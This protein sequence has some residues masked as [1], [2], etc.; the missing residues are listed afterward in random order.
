VATDWNP[1][2]GGIVNDISIAGTNVYVAG[3][4]TTIGGQTRNRIAALS[5]VTGL[6]TAWN[7]SATAQVNALAL[8]GNTVYAGGT[9][10]T[11]GGQPRNRIAALDADRVGYGLESQYSQWRRQQPRRGR[12]RGVRRRW[13]HERR[14]FVAQFNRGD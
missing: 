4:F 14:Q 7:P 3:N 13:V 6:A 10:T 2:F 11:I 12:Q 1:N 8:D 5:T 9:F